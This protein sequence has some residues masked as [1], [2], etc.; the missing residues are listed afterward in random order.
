[1]AFFSFVPWKGSGKPPAGKPAGRNV[2]PA[3]PATGA[4]GYA[5][6]GPSPIGVAGQHS[7]TGAFDTEANS[8]FLLGTTTP[9]S[10]SWLESV[11]YDIETQTLYIDFAGKGRTKTVTTCRYEGIDPDTALSLLLAPSKGRW[12]HFHLIKTHYPYTVVGSAK[13]FGGL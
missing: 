5:T 3:A 6:G 2:I 12:V 7:S 11:V 9:V 10:S 1:M 13:I 8:A 4:R